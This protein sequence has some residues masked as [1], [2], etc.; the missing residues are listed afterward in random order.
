MPKLVLCTTP[1]VADDPILMP[2]PSR[3][4]PDELE[5]EAKLLPTLMTRRRYPWWVGASMM[6]LN[7]GCGE[8]VFGTGGEVK[9]ET[10]VNLIVYLEEGV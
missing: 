5:F 8:G 2:S 10:F 6:D 7:C 4:I 1:I 3:P 9:G